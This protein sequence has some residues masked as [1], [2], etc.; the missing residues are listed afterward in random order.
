MRVF[1]TSFIVLVVLAAAAAAG[2]AWWENNYFVRPG[3]APAQTVLVIVPGSGLNRIAA[4]LAQAGVVENGLL[5][6]AGVMRRGRTAQLK[7]GEYA[8]PAHASEA[9]VMDMLVSA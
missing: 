7:A 8:F 1:F 4:A 3:P 9:Q 6:R 2:G 5:F